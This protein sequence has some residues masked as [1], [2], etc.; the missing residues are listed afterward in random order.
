M[1]KLFLIALGLIPLAVR[2]QSQ[3]DWWQA[4][5]DPEMDGLVQAALA[6]HGSVQAGQARV[7]AAQDQVDANKAYY[8]PNLSVDPLVQQQNLAPNRPLPINA[9]GTRFTLN[10]LNLPLNLAY[11]LNFWQKNTL[12]RQAQNQVQQ[13][14]AN[15]DQSRLVLAAQVVQT[16]LQIRTADL[17]LAVLQRNIGLLDSIQRILDARYK[18]GLT[19]EVSLTLNRTQLQSL[20]ADVENTARARAEALAQ[21]EALT[22]RPGVQV[23]AVGSNLTLPLLDTAGA[24]KA[25]AERPDVRL[26]DYQIAS[27]KLTIQQLDYNRL[28]RPF[29][30]GSTGLTSKTPEVLLKQNSFTYTI[31]AGISIPIWNWQNNRYQV[32]AAKAEV[33]AREALY[34]QQNLDATADLRTAL[35]N[36]NRTQAQIASLDQ[37]LGTAQRAIRLSSELYTKGLTSFLELLNAEQNIISLQTRRANLTGQYLQYVA[38]YYLARGGR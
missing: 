19:N 24:A 34:R 37:A 22:N 33:K 26:F 32:R 21:L 23:A 31:G 36:L 8:I 1:R 15:L 3:Q 25:I 14:G 17:T 28:P 10:S 7:D 12:V 11:D 27:G 18:A 4:F 20:A 13:Q 35:S 38:S 5:R 30:S 9:V 2:A 29:V 6:A 16:V